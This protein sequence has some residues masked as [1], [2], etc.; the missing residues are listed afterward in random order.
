LIS[1]DSEANIKCQ[2]RQCFES[3]TYRTNTSERV[4]FTLSRSSQTDVMERNCII[5]IN[6]KTE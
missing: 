5:D 2:L 3:L 6:A 1:Y 4:T